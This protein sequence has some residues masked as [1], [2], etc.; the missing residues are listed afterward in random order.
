ML[1]DRIHQKHHEK[2]KMNSQIQKIV[3]LGGG[4]AGWITAA[5]LI[6]ILKKNFCS[7]ELIESKDIGTIGVGE[8]T[9]GSIINYI[10]A[11]GINEAD[12]IRETQSTYKLGIQFKDWY[13]LD[14]EY[15]HP[16]GSAGVNIN[17]L[18]FFPFWLKAK[19][20]GHTSNFTDFAPSAV[21][22]E[23]NRFYHHQ[24]AP[25]ESFLAGSSYALHVDAN[26]VGKY[27]RT[28]AIEKGVKRIEATVESVTQKENGFIDSLI[29]TDGTKV[30]GDFFID[31]TGFSSLLIE[32]TL[33][34]GFEDWQK[35]LPCDR[36]IAMPTQNDGALTPYTIATARRSGWTWKIAL[37]S[38]T[39]N[40]YV[41]SSKFESESDAT[42]LLQQV[43]TGAPIAEPRSLK[44]ITGHRKSIWL[45]N[46]VAI[47]LSS[48]FVE[49]LES[50]AIHLIMKGARTFLE[51]FPDNDCD[52]QLAREYNRIMEQEYEN[53]RDFIVLHYCVTKRT[54]TEFWRWC[55]NDMLIPD[56]LKEK[57]EL[58]QT[59]GKLYRNPEDLFKDP[60]WYSV[61]EGMGIRPQ[62]YDP[63]VNLTPPHQ[64]LSVMDQVKSLMLQMAMGLPEHSAYIKKFITK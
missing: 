64:I 62:K 24:K 47:G 13:Q 6:H 43:V 29:L 54:D 28:Y 50:T 21:M 42:E 52:P 4:T 10:N 16:F 44:F 9:I 3:I 15:F 20:L 19:K 14:Q 39:G 60:S 18:P 63:L 36:A 32:K 12:F 2:N 5:A 56:S 23:H 33:K 45:K 8:A 38:R 48:G 34:S 37:Q 58:F 17:G 53:I 49:P 11:L 40:G 57:I 55:Q 25:K 31:C 26:L 22:A 35:Y 7:I 59:Q 46:C 41:Y 27:L 61:F 51:L 30:Q 1:H